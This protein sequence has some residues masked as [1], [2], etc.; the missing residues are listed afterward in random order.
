M[1]STN[2]RIIFAVVAL[3]IAAVVLVVIISPPE[4]DS[5]GNE[6]VPSNVFAK[7]VSLSPKSYNS[8]DFTDFFEKARQAGTVVSW[9]G[10]WNDLNA[11]NGGAAVVASLSS[12]YGYVAVIELQFFQQSSGALLRPLDNATMQTFKNSAVAFAEKYQP[13][14]LALGIEVNVLFE[15]APN[16]FE[17]FVNF[18]NDVYDAVKAES[19]QTKIFPIFQLRKNER[20]KWRTLRQSK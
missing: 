2:K 16:D 7:G 5:T 8:S 11:E 14:Y 10:D 18:Y 3:L 15:K 17:T 6:N 12:T 4:Q 19:P 20:T 1:P 13:R 9:A